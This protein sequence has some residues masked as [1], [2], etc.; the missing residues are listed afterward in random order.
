[1]EPGV[2]QILSKFWQISGCCVFRVGHYLCVSL[3]NS[4]WLERERGVSSPDK[5]FCKTEISPL[6]K[7]KV[8]GIRIVCI[9]LRNFVRI[10]FVLQEGSDI[11]RTAIKVSSKLTAR[12]LLLLNI[13]L[14]TQLI[15]LKMVK[16]SPF[17]LNVQ[18]RKTI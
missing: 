2:V 14:G 17:G 18:F 6:S 15:Q 9:S 3:Y 10:F 7:P 16:W 12:R 13:K 4:L 11:T 5:R 1:M 8:L